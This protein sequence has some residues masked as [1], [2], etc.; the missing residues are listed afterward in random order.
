MATWPAADVNLVSLSLCLSFCLPSLSLCE[1]TVLSRRM[2]KTSVANPLGFSP[3]VSPACSFSPGV[4]VYRKRQ[5]VS[6]QMRLFF[7]KAVGPLP[8]DILDGLVNGWVERQELG[9]LLYVLYALWILNC[10]IFIQ[11]YITMWHF[12]G[13]G[14]TKPVGVL[15]VGDI[16]TQY[17]PFTL[18]NKVSKKGQQLKKPI[19]S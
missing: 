6:E 14:G 8:G 12:L 4:W 1:W 3:Y 11:T 13:D 2:E 18:K 19:F 16:Q 10:H 5:A 7:G 9:G 15:T 17:P